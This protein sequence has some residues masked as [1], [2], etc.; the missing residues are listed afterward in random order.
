MCHILVHSKLFLFFCKK[1]RIIIKDKGS[2]YHFVL[3]FFVVCSY[4]NSKIMQMTC[5]WVASSSRPKDKKETFGRKKPGTTTKNIYISLM[6]PMLVASD[7][8]KKFRFFFETT[9]EKQRQRNRKWLGL[10]T[11][12][13]RQ[14]KKY[15]GLF[16]F[17]YVF[18][19]GTGN[20]MLMMSL[21]KWEG[22][23]RRE[24]KVK[25][26]SLSLLIFHPPVSTPFLHHGGDKDKS[27]NKLNGATYVRR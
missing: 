1:T 13:K 7:A 27:E 8:K 12:R 18:V 23:M 10:K 6:S 3:S 26:L 16:S 15:S 14:G 2:S 24:I 11:S 4:T 19:D 17:A 5:A 9:S 25:R 21:V 22:S 20:D